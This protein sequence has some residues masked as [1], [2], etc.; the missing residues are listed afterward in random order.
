MTARLN[1]AAA[2]QR[3]R[4]KVPFR[5]E[6]AHRLPQPDM[7]PSSCANAARMRFVYDGT[8]SSL[9]ID[10]DALHPGKHHVSAQSASILYSAD[11][12]PAKL[13]Q[14]PRAAQLGC[15]RLQ[16]FHTA[17]NEYT[18]HLILIPHTCL[19]KS[20]DRANLA[21]STPGADISVICLSHQ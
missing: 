13:A 9:D 5:Y 20:T 1:A 2:T 16:P 18:I 15:R 7:L 19:E 3:L 8:L 6:L 12:H 4:N 17:T 14:R 11:K 21:L 10:L